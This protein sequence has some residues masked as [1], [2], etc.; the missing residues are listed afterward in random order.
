MAI[1][2]PCCVQSQRHWLRRQAE[3]IT[4]PVTL[5]GSGSVL[6]GA[7][8]LQNNESNA[9]KG[10]CSGDDWDCYRPAQQNLIAELARLPGCVVVI[11]GDYHAA[12]IK[13]ILP[14]EAAGYRDF[15]APQV[16]HASRLAA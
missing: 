9:F 4:A 15:Y 16:L 10:Y 12:D 2:A 8:S 5:V 3:S 11:T 14:G 1:A 6:F 13:R 7:P